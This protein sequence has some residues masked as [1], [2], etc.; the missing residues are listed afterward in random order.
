MK[1]EEIYE[2]ARQLPLA[3]RVQLVEEIWNSIG[4]ANEGLPVTEEQKKELDVRLQ[5]Y[6]DGE[7]QLHEWQDFHQALRKS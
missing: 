4:D 2:Q 6:V 5:S 3:E 7:Q 1:L